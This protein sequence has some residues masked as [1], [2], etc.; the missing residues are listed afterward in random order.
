M[1]KKKILSNPRR[2]KTLKTTPSFR[3]PHIIKEENK[4]VWV[5][6]E[7]G[8]PSTLAITPLMRIH[9]PGYKSCLCN[10]E[11]FIKMGGKI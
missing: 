9:Y 3:F 10:K 6:I 7:S 4:E 8:F 1:N 2:F 11:T 5:Y